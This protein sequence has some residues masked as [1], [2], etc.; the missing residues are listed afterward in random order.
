MQAA[1]GEGDGA[2]AATGF[3]GKAEDFAGGDVEADIVDGTKVLFLADIVDREVFD[4]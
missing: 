1:D 3:A 2:L 4:G